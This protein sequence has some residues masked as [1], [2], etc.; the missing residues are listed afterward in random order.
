MKRALAVKMA[1]QDEPYANITELLSMHKSCISSWK[2]KFVSQGLAGIK[3]G[4]KG[5]KSY[6]TEAQRASVIAWLKAK[7]SWDLEEL[8]THI[9]EDYG[10]IYQAKQSYYELFSNAEISWKKTQKTNPKLEPELVKKKR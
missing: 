4:Y 3:L 2:Q 10:V 9:D 1:L 5:A 8:V 7:K 6:L